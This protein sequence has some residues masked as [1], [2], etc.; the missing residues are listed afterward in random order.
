VSTLADVPASQ[1]H[2]QAIGSGLRQK[3]GPHRRFGLLLPLSGVVGVWLFTLHRPRPHFTD[4]SLKEVEAILDVR[5]LGRDVQLADA[6]VPK[7]EARTKR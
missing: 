6:V 5:Y 3:L 2:N 7:F 4:H 1:H